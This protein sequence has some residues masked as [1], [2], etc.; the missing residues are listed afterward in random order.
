MWQTKA[1]LPA[2]KT[3]RG[4]GAGA[5]HR[6]TSLRVYWRC[7]QEDDTI[8]TD[9]TVRCWAFWLLIDPLVRLP[10]EDDVP[11]VVEPVEVP[12]VDPVL[13]PDAR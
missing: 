2:G 3:R 5:A 10:V 4:E 12:L 1:G 9:S 13:D 11:L 8:F 7:V 6:R